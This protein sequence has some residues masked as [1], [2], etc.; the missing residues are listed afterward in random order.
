MSEEQQYDVNELTIYDFFEYWPTMGLAATALALYAVIALVVGLMT[1]KR[2]S[3]RFVHLITVTC[4]CEAGGY[5]AL[6][7]AIDQSGKTSVFNAYVAMQVLIILAPNLIQAAMYWLAAWCWSFSPDSCGGRKRLRGW[8]IT[9]TFAGADLF[10]II[11]QAAGISIWA[12]S[13]SSGNPDQDQIRLGCGITLAGLA[14]QLIC[15]IAFTVLTI[16]THRHPSNG[17]TGKAETRKLF[18]GLYFGMAMLYIRNLFRFVEFVQA[19]VLEWPPPDDTYVLSEQQVLFYTLD[20]LPIL[21]SVATYILVHPGFLLPEPSAKK[22]QVADVEE[23]EQQQQQHGAGKKGQGEPSEGS[24]DA[25]QVSV[26]EEEPA[27]V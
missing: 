15:F 24:S 27:R 7:Y 17:L 8:V 18:I 12:S 22:G 4:L 19:T 26:I 16:W 23:G 5:A 10:A 14:I 2:R 11:V 1:E 20:T 3:Y 21:L 25:F 6:V 9:T 13:Q